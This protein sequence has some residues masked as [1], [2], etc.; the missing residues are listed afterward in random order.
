MARASVSETKRKLREL[1]KLE[2]KIRRAES[3]AGL[4]LVWNDFFTGRNSPEKIAEADKET[5][6][7]IIEEYFFRV[8]YKIHS[9]TGS[10]DIFYDPE[11]LSRLGLPPSAGLDAIKQ[12]FRELAKK[13]HPDAG[14]DAS[15]FI[16][17]R[18]DY[19][20]LSVSSRKSR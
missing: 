20:S 6:K 18:D 16:K 1:K 5:Y 9:E 13:Y 7:K 15:D 12:K 8:Y 17:L 10:D 19:E 2:K 3:D 11:I 4:K 14:G